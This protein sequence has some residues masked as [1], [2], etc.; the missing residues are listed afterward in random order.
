M[1]PRFEGATTSELSCPGGTVRVVVAKSFRL[2]LLGL[3]GLGAAEI[4]P[5]LFPRCRSVHTFGMK[6]PIDL[7]WLE[8]TGDAPQIL[9]VLEGLSPRRVAR[10]PSDRRSHHAVSALELAAGHAKRL[11]FSAAEAL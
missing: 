10:A 2:R 7:V 11:G 9:G 6:S 3:L 4:V 5:L 8:G 1:H